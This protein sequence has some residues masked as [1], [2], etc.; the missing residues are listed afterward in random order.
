MLFS[1][2]IPVYNRS[3][4]L[5]ELL[6]SIRKQSFRDFELIVVDD[7]SKYP[8]KSVCE[9]YNELTINYIYKENG[10]PAS[11]RNA[12]ARLA[13][14]EYLLF[15]DSDTLIPDSYF[16]AI[17]AYLDN[18]RVDLFGGPDMSDPSF[19]P[20]Q[21]AISYTMTS[22]F[23]TGG[24]RGGK[25]KLGRFIPRSFNMGVR[26]EAFEAVGGFSP[27]RFGEDMDFSMRLMERGFRSALIPQAAIYHK[28]RTSLRAFY[29]QVLNSGRARIEL[30]IRHKGSLKA[31]HLLPLAFMI[32]SLALVLLSIMTGSLIPA[33]L[34]LA[35]CLILLIDSSIKEKSLKVGLLSILTAFVQL[36]AYALGFLDNLFKRCILRGSEVQEIDNERF[37]S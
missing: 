5:S 8:C 36:Y 31:V 2:I 20:L 32:G 24:I 3:E 27:M 15:L 33:S 19:S 30:S 9:E 11:A 4:E 14:G 21:K 10:G 16:D 35:Y 18:D 13:K 25:K 7:G 37:Y 12:G 17:L 1:L 23:T 28:R 34:L 22:F 29:R 6:E 26:R